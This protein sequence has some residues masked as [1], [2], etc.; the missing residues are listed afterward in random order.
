MKSF[1]KKIVPLAMVAWAVV[2][3]GCDAPTTALVE[4]EALEEL[5]TESFASENLTS[6]LTEELELSTAQLSTLQVEMNRRDRPEKSPGSLWFVSVRLQEHLSERQKEKLFRV[7]A[8]QRDGHL[9]KLV[10][11][12]GPCVVGRPVDDEYPERLPIRLILDVL[13]DEQL[14]A[15]AQIRERYRN[16]IAEIREQLRA[17]EISREEATRR[18]KSLHDALAEE[19]RELL[20]EDQIAALRER[21]AARGDKVADHVAHNRRAMIEALGLGDDQ[22]AALDELH[23]SQC[24]SLGELIRKARAGEITRVELKNGVE[25]LV[26]QKIEAYER[27][28]ESKQ[29]EAAKIHDA[30]LV[31]NARRF[32]HHVTDHR[33]VTDRE[34]DGS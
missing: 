32:V 10:G 19:I 26:I 27:I 14:E 5:Y 34:N 25:R 12:Y 33:P 31:I 24:S 2:L 3:V 21:L 18:V 23:R 11:V 20:T 13:T 7:A 6:I 15:A 1:I 4:S 8:R 28:L 22:I 16:Q 17:G 30:L 9:R 29:L